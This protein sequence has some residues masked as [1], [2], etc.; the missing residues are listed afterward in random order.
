MSI[1][2]RRH[3]HRT[4]EQILAEPK[5]VL[6][7][8]REHCDKLSPLE[9]FALKITD[10]V[11]SPTFFL[12]IFFWTITWTGYNIAAPY[13][14]LKAFDPFPAFVAYL[15]ISNVIQIL[16]MPLI[17][18]GQNLQSRHSEIRAESDFEINVR[19]EQEITEILL[20][21]EKHQEMMEQIL[22]RLDA[23]S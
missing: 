6:N 9:I 15:L 4:P 8:N 13:L 1:H 2:K 18:V 19:A 22:K 10:K 12:L 14:G 21:L 3:L 7:P 23:K 16:L 5:A 11:G 20:R 17:M